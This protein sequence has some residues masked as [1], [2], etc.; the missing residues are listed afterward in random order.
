MLKKYLVEMHNNKIPFIVYLLLQMLIFGSWPYFCNFT[1]SYLAAVPN[2]FYAFISLQRTL[3][4]SISKISVPL[5]SSI[6]SEIFYRLTQF[7]FFFNGHIYKLTY[8]FLNSITLKGPP[9]SLLIEQVVRGTQNQKLI[10]IVAQIVLNA[11]VLELA[12]FT[13]RKQQK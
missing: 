7:Y 4:Y 2:S 10:K 1:G 11:G 9:E 12:S 8:F 13:L 3:T 6:Q 5:S